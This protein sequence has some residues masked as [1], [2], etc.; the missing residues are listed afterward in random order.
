MC[1][2]YR[3]LMRSRT[4]SFS[5]QTYMKYVLQNSILEN[6]YRLLKYFKM[7]MMRILVLLLSKLFIF[8][9]VS[10]FLLHLSPRVLLVGRYHLLMTMTAITTT[11][12]CLEKSNFELAFP[13]SFSW[14][15]KNLSRRKHNVQERDSKGTLTQRFHH[16]CLPK[17]VESG[18]Y[19]LCQQTA[20]SCK[21]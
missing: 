18:N 14:S 10:D 2:L 17:D 5:L 3:Q 11:I 1:S 7:S 13:A 9:I 15:N 20:L 8:T 19:K 12:S 16:F 4:S 21:K 6:R